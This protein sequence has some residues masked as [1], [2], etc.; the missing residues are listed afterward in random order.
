M[1]YIE[2]VLIFDDLAFAWLR[3]SLVKPVTLP[4]FP[5][6]AFLLWLGLIEERCMSDRSQSYQ[7]QPPRAH[8]G[9]VRWLRITLHCRDEYVKIIVSESTCTAEFW[10]EFDRKNLWYSQGNLWMSVCTVLY[11]CP[12]DIR[13]LLDMLVPSL[14]H[15]VLRFLMRSLGVLL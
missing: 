10:K 8:C 7:T 9:M 3:L 6:H 1:I 13:Q 5:E 2:V 4:T 12:R 14:L 11:E 15:S